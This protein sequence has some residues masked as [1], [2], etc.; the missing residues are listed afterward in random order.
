MK[1]MV[2]DQSNHRKLEMG[3]HSSHLMHHFPPYIFGLT[4]FFFSLSGAQI[5]F[6][7]VYCFDLI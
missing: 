3:R 1:V 6:W 5:N 2:K 7:F 4:G